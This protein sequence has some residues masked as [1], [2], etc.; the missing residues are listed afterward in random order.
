METDRKLCSFVRFW[1]PCRFEFRGGLIHDMRDESSQVDC[2]IF[3]RG[4]SILLGYL[5]EGT[6]PESKRAY[7]D[8]VCPLLWWKSRNHPALSIQRGFD[9]KESVGITVL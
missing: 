3:L 9:R 5:E 7:V 8:L 4:H 2:G 1:S 6:L